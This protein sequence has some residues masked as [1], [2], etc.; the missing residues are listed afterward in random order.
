MVK[1]RLT[2]VKNSDEEKKVLKALKEQFEII[3]ISREYEGRGNS[4]YCN[5]YIDVKVGDRDDI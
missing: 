5:L 1:I 2:H 4:E 3:S